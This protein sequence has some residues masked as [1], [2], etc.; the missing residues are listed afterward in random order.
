MLNI[1]LSLTLYGCEA[2]CRNPREHRLKV[3]GDVVL[4]E[5]YSPEKKE[6]SAVRRVNAATSPTSQSRT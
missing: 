5:I 1:I 2:C 4:K 6:E 3:Y